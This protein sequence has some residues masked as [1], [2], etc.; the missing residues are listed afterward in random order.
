MTDRDEYIS[1]LN[2]TNR[3]RDMNFVIF[4]P[5]KEDKF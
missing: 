1:L 3:D 4:N 5:D 2:L